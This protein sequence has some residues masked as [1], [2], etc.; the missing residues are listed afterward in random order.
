MKTFLKLS[1]IFIFLSS[2]SL[3]VY[4]QTAVAGDDQEVCTDQTIMA[5]DPPPINYTGTWS[6]ISGSC[7]IADNTLYNTQVT[8]LLADFNELRWILVFYRLIMILR[9]KRL[10]RHPAVP[11]LPF[12][13]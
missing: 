13:F 8:D 5:A 11:S 6:V 2:V 3:S 9:H 7:S 12:G 1:F 10:M 4:S